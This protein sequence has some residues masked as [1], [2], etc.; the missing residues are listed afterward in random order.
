MEIS[1]Q[2]VVFCFFFFFPSSLNVG[3]CN[4]SPGDTV[5]SFAWNEILWRNLRLHGLQNNLTRII[6]FISQE[7]ELEHVCDC[8][9]QLSLSS[10]Q[11]KKHFNFHVSEQ[12]FIFWGICSY[13]ALFFLS[14]CPSPLN[15]VI[16]VLTF[17]PHVHPSTPVGVS[18]QTPCVSLSQLQA[19]N[20]LQ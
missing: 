15:A 10:Y 12:L 18:E 8:G 11:K 20:Y 3:G 6:F 5:A 9:R 4:R 14:Q 7:K 1:C 19:I 13:S 16:P 2:C 17:S